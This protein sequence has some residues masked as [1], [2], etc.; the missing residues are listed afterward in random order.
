MRI[1]IRQ[2]DC[3]AA[4]LLKDGEHA[5]LGS[6]RLNGRAREVAGERLGISRIKMCWSRSRG[7]ELQRQCGSH[8]LVLALTACA[9]ALLRKEGG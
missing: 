4:V 9:K 8:L 6:A 1:I 3:G 5:V 7:D 2:H